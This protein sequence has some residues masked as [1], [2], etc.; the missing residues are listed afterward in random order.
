MS[1]SRMEAAAAFCSDGAV[2]SKGEVNALPFSLYRRLP[3]VSSVEHH[4][5]TL[6]HMSNTP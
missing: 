6:P 4:S 2:R 3:G 5:Q 1:L